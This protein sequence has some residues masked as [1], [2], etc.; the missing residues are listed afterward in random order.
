MPVKISIKNL[1]HINT[2]NFTIPDKGVWLLTG[3][4]GTGKTSLLAC[5]RRIGERNAFPMHFKVSA[6]SNNLDSFAGASVE[7]DVNGVKVKYQY[8]GTRWTPRPK[9]NASALR[10]AGYP[11]V[12]YIA[13]DARRIEPRPE[14][15]KPRGVRAAHASIIAGANNIFDT[16]RFNDL[17]TIN[18]SRGVGNDAFLIELPARPGQTG[19]NYASERNFSLGELCIIKLLRMLKDCPARSLV[20]IDELELALH[21][22]AQVALL[23]H[24][25]DVAEQKNLTVIVSTHSAT[26]IK[27]AGE[28]RLLLLQNDGK[29]NI[30]CQDKCFPSMVLGA[31]AY[32]EENAADRIIYVE[33]DAA[34]VMVDH[35]VGKVCHDLYP[36]L[37][38]NPSVQ[39]VPVGGFVNV[40]RF[41]KY[42]KA[43]V[44]AITR[45]FVLL[46][47]D[48]E[49]S[50]ANAVQPDVIA[51]R[52]TEHASISYL[53]VTPE[54]GLA[55]YLDQHTS[56]VRSALRT[57]YNLP[58]LQFVKADLGVL[59][60]AYP[61]KPNKKYVWAAC[62]KI[63]ERLPNGDA[64][65]VEEVLLKLLAN[66]LFATDRATI[67]QRM[68][69][70][71]S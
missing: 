67:M 35:L 27:Q 18:L 66:H 6:Q 53:T 58:G 16:Q 69:P 20:L 57:H 26:L 13:A 24:L 4:N 42:Q 3:P 62:E 50:L 43:L 61:R 63:A 12:L 14:D 21:P 33:D 30:T 59:P 45:C 29:G 2:L 47:A 8:S 7:Y 38:P 65:K 41:F 37:A 51:I 56:D 39:S 40:L 34:K 60:P 5:I 64:N 11:G 9:P 52:D 49:P 17:K 55:Q 22:M 71:L 10:T 23:R 15:F 68:S 46:D 70:L 48:A 1:K 32:G 19:K 44:P 28:Q 54:V 36:G 25:D 31:L